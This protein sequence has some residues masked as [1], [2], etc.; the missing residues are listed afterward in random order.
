MIVKGLESGQLKANEFDLAM[1]ERV[2]SFNKQS[3]IAQKLFKEKKQE[4]AKEAKAFKQKLAQ[5]VKI[6]DE[7]GG[8]ASMGKALFSA[9]CLS[10]H[11]VGSEG[12]GFA[13]PLD[14]SAHRE[15]EALL[16]AILDPD[17]AVESNYYLYRLTKKDGTTVEGYREKSDDKGTTMRFMGGG[18]VFVPSSDIKNGSFVGNRSVMPKGLIDGLSK[19]QIA[20]ILA[21]IRT[22]K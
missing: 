18:K 21:Y 7:K 16:T 8:Q 15:N 1:A 3:S 12:A 13:P 10:C 9:L 6:A 14:G 22:L 2:L 17:A 20:D 5:F 19:D 11:S 4:E